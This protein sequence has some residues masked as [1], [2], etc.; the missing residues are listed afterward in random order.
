[1]KELIDWLK[2]QKRIG[3]E[4]GTTQLEIDVLQAVIDKAKA[5][6][7]LQA[8]VIGCKTIRNCRACNKEI[9]CDKEFCNQ[10]CKTA[11]YR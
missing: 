1:M 6:Q 7:L 3:I 5:L 10:K 9:T 4:L 2:N 8:N 11:Y